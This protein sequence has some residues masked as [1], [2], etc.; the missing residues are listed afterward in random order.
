M[1]II[2]RLRATLKPQGTAPAVQLRLSGYGLFN[3][4]FITQC[5]DEAERLNIRVACGD[6]PTALEKLAL[7]LLLD[8]ADIDLEHERK[9]REF[10]DQQKSA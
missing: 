4:D 1:S 2:S 6:R 3:A 5:I 10:L 8:S 7:N 9:Q